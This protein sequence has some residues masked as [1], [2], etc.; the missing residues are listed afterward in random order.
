ML[1]RPNVLSVLRNMRMEDF[2]PRGTGF[3]AFCG[4]Y[5]A[6]WAHFW[7]PDRIQGS[8]GPETRIWPNL[9]RCGPNCNSEG[10]LLGCNL[11]LLAIPTPQNGPN[12]HARA[13]DPS[14]G[15]DF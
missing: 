7:A 9:R 1:S 4:P 2:E 15:H 6:I 13:L 14:F 3:G 11:P 8:V 10:T 5:A 12:I